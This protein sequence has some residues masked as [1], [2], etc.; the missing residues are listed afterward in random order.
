MAYLHSVFL[1][2]PRRLEVAEEVAQARDLL[3]HRVAARYLFEVEVLE[4]VEVDEGV[5]RE[6]GEHQEE[7]LDVR[8][9]DGVAQ[10]HRLRGWCE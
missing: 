4:K 6:D 3:R 9:A 2:R 5:L 7:Q 10:R 1:R 8:V